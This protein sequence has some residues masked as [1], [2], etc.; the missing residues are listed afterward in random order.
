MENQ[1]LR[2]IVKQLA[3]SIRKQDFLTY[4]KKISYLGEIEGVIVL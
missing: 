1:I 4:F 2:N 3:Q